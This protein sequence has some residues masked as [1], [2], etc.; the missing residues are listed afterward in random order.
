MAWRIALLLALAGL[1]W[2]GPVIWPEPFFSHC[3]TQGRLSL[4]SGRPFD[5]NHARALL[6]DIAARLAHSPLNDENPHCIFVANSAWRSILLMHNSSA[7]AISLYPLTR[8]VFVGSA[9]IDTNI[10]FHASGER[11]QPPR[12]FVYYVAHEITHALTG[13]HVGVVRFG[14]MP[15]WV[16]EGYADY[17]GMGNGGPEDD[18]ALLYMRYRAHDPLFADERSYYRFRML[19]AYFLGDRGWSLDKLLATT[20]TLDQAQRAMDQA[21]PINL[22]K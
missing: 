1:A 17:V 7:A 18:P 10:G 5:E 3:I 15:V 13:E 14:Q 21:P 20:M 6:S 22:L 8:N 19:A 4:C 16:R 9:D 11:A 12:T 2:R